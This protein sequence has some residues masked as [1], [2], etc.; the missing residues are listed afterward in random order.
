MNTEAVDPRRES[1]LA[2]ADSLKEFEDQRRWYSFKSSHM[3]ERA[4][5]LDIS[6]IILGALIAAM[7]A[8]KPLGASS[9]NFDIAVAVLGGAVVFCQGLHRVLR[10]GETW[11]EYRRASER[12]KSERRKFVN[13]VPPYDAEAEAAA[14]IAYIEAMERAIEEEQKLYFT[15]VKPK[16]DAKQ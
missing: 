14:R 3:K 6:I 12:M 1:R 13:G 11:P 2:Y 7:P 8:I 10:F 4:Q 16:R 9:A 5:A 15:S